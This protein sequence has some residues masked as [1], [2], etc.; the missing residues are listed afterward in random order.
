V[1]VPVIQEKIVTVKEVV[2]K[3]V[4]EKYETVKIV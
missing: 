3:V 1:E 2:E 4:A